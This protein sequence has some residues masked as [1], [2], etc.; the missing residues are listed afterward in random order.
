MSGSASNS[1]EPAAAARPGNVED[2][3]QAQASGASPIERALDPEP[4]FDLSTGAVTGTVERRLQSPLLD[5]FRTGAALQGGLLKALVS[6]AGQPENLPPGTHLGP[7]RLLHLLGAGGMSEVYLAERADGRFE[8]TVAI[9]VVHQRSGLSDRL[10]HERQIIATLRHPHIVSLVDG[11]ETEGGAHWFAMALVEGKMLD[12]YVQDR[13]LSWRQVLQL[14]HQICAAVEYAH[15]RGLIHR[16]LKPANILVDDQG[17][18]RL[19]DF[20][21]ALAGDTDDGRDDR[22][23]TPG[24]A[25]PEQNRGEAITTA[26]DLYQLGLILRQLLQLN[27][28]PGQTWVS[29]PKRVR[30]DLARVLA[31]ATA[32]SPD[33]RH[34]S[35]AAFR[36]DLSAVLDC[37][38]IAEDRN[39]FG[40]RLQR[41]T[42]RHRLAVT[43]AMVAGITLLA[44]LGTAAWQLRE[45]RN[46]AIANEQRANAVAD[47][48]VETLSQGNPYSGKK[49]E[50]SVVA[51]I[52]QAANTL[53]ARLNDAPAVR[54]ALRNTIATVYLNLDE[55]KRCL[56]LIATD[57]AASDW[58]GASAAEQGRYWIT[59]SECHLALD[60]REPALAMLERAEQA[61]QSGSGAEVER[62]W[63]WVMIDQAQIWA[64]DGRLR[65]AEDILNRALVLATRH[66]DL[67]QEYRAYRFLGG[68]ASN[69]SRAALAAEL[70]SKS[71]AAAVKSLGAGHRSTLTVAGQWAMALSWSNQHEQAVALIESTLATARSVK[72]REA[73]ADIVIAQLLDNRAGIYW[74]MGRSES[75]IDD[76]QAA[77]A[78]YRRLAAPGS[79]QPFNPS[80]RSATCAYQM[81]D[82]QSARQ[83]ATEALVYA[84]LGVSVGVINVE[85]LLASVAIEQGQLDVARAHLD[86]AHERAR[87]TEVANPSVFTGIELAEAKWA[88]ARQ[89]RASAESWLAKADQ[90]IA[91]HQVQSGWIPEE[92]RLV[93]ERLA[94]LPR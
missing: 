68:I 32:A 51:A 54:R 42:E 52:D 69:S 66:G 7:W 16:D 4:T 8:Q 36:D 29:M 6:Q 45:E 12:A 94:R 70:F 33:A 92:R 83:F 61:L 27:A 79:S 50:V 13:R 23:L 2:S 59:R 87:S 88:V 11:G 3:D 91:D 93:A 81:Q 34:A 80:W 28:A 58:Q 60:Q 56:D 49:G 18:P 25:S 15:G 46:Q 10:R 47:F 39:R 73:G 5:R 72:H 57:Q 77:V 22:V 41:L 48:L 71:H 53:D 64:L 26:S 90:R 1:P 74:V 20:G 35:V 63:A 44:V 85:R 21:I 62:V 55:A 84:E 37:Q 9:K 67:E 31:R 19:L 30:S 17:H 40:I 38:P 76:A 89:D 75:C 86:R 14:F 82:W 24:F 78:I 43:I 65:E